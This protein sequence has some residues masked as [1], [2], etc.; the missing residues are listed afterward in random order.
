MDPNYLVI[1]HVS[2]RS[3]KQNQSLGLILRMCSSRHSHVLYGRVPSFA[4]KYPS[5]IIFGAGARKES[6]LSR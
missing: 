3:I 6:D 4:R 5:S 1:C 2:V